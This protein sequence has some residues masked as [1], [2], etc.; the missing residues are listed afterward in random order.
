M[1]LVVSECENKWRSY[2]HHLQQA[3]RV[4]WWS[5]LPSWVL[6]IE[7]VDIKSN[8][9]WFAKKTIMFTPLTKFIVLHMSPCNN[10]LF[11]HQPI[12]VATLRTLTTD[13]DNIVATKIKSRVSCYVFYIRPGSI[14]F[15][16]YGDVP[17]PAGEP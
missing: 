10:L 7:T 16:D 3:Q 12:Y 11:G 9:S 15:S 17:L 8:S 14:K 1:K 2:L 6:Q 4:F 5:V 13:G